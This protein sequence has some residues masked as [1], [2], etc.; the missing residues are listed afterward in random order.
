MV[1]VETV[2]HILLEKGCHAYSDRANDMCV[3]SKSRDP[4]LTSV[5]NR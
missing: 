1:M 4:S 5:N 3:F 2:Q